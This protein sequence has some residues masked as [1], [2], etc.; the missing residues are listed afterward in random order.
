MAMPAA[1]Q[2]IYDGRTMK[3]FALSTLLVLSVAGCARINDAGMRL[4]A[5]SAP[6]LAIVE[7]TP[8]S[9][10]AVVAIDRSGT[11]NLESETEPKV[12]C[13]GTMRYTATTSGVATLKCSN[14]VDVL[15]PFNAIS[16]T[17][18]YGSG[19]TAQGVASFTF[20]MDLEDAI[21]YLRP[22]AGKR[23]VATP[24]GAVRL[25]PL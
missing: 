16:E 24:E 7:D 18:G 25:A 6:A 22:P 5:S 2:F 8:L 12:K 3:T 20:G 17:K 1:A 14:G 9:G 11:L 10:K 4:V 23:I 21:A 15:M 13:M 19:R